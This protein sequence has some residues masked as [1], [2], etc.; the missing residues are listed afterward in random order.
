MGFPSSS[1]AF[2]SSK[3]EMPDITRNWIGK[4]EWELRYRT[5]FNGSGY[6]VHPSV[7]SFTMHEEVH[8]RSGRLAYALDD[9][10][11]NYPPHGTPWSLAWVGLA[12]AKVCKPGYHRYGAAIDFTKVAWGPDRFVDL[13]VHGKDDRL[14]LRR[15]YLAVVAMCRKYFG[16]VLHVNNDPDGSHWNHIHADR[17]RQVVAFDWDF[18]TD[19]TIIQ[20]AARDLAGMSEMVIDGIWGPQ[21]RSGYQLLRG[22]FKSDS[23]D[24]TDSSVKGRAWLDLIARHAMADKDAGAYTLEL[25]GDMAD[26]RRIMGIVVSGML[27][28]AGLAGCDGSSADD[29]EPGV[30]YGVGDD[31]RLWRWDVSTDETEAVL[32]LGGVW[33]RSGDVGLVFQSTLSIAPD[34]RHASWVSGGTPD[35]DLRI[36]DLSTG[37]VTGSVPYPVDHVCLDPVW[38][39][40]GSAVLAHRAKVWDETGAP[41]EAFGPTEWFSPQGEELETETDL[42]EGCRLRWYSAGRD[43]EGATEGIYHDLEVTELYRVDESGKRFKTIPIDSLSGVDAEVTGLVAVDPSGRYVCLADGYHSQGGYEG[44]FV[45]RPQI[46]SKVIDLATGK[47][48]GKRGESCESLTMDGYLAREGTTARFIDYGG[49]TLWEAELPSELK[50][51][52]NLFYF[53]EAP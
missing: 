26:R 28:A 13:A 25:G 23:V 32:D 37:E 3:C 10:G 22:R 43:A 8:D 46:G 16:T 38:A 11:R 2:S 19:V 40:D 5:A 7:T 41:I 45:I 47:A 12:G 29:A 20:W 44:G 53:E 24:P 1:E 17:G 30:L 4:R 51:S 15:R 27:M 35:S 34:Q 39:P 6:G 49:E 48:A 14:R 52:P 18:G 42:D 21:T 36:A 31:H 33:D 9:L 50:D